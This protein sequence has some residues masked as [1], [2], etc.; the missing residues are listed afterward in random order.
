MTAIGIKAKFV[1]LETITP[2]QAPNGSL[3]LDSTNAN[4]ATIKNVSGVLEPIDAG[5]GSNLFIKQMQAG[6]AFSVNTPLSKRPDGKVVS[7]DSD[8]LNTQNHIGFALSAS[9][10]D[11]DLINVLCVGA[12]IVGAI[13]SL[14]FTPGQDIYLSEG[15]GYTNDANSFTGANDSVIKVGIA[16]CSAGN[17]SSVANDL[18][19]LTEVIIRP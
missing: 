9:L 5:S 11:G 4:A 6:A 16:D 10:S 2:A 7:S 1:L 14:G 3:F 13:S 8:G 18:I 19:I 17:A 12:N 15:G